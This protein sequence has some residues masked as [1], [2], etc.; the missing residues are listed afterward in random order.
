MS[1]TTGMDYLDDINGDDVILRSGGYG[2]D[3][4]SIGDWTD[5]STTPHQN[6]SET[7]IPSQTGYA[8]IAPMQYGD[9][10]SMYSL[11]QPETYGIQSMPEPEDVIM[12]HDSIPTQDEISGAEKEY[13]M[14]LDYDQPYQQEGF[15]SVDVQ[16][17]WHGGQVATQAGQPHLSTD[18]R[19]VQH[20][21]PEQHSHPAYGSYDPANMMQNRQMNQGPSYPPSDDSG[22]EQAGRQYDI[23]H[24][25]SLDDLV[26]GNWRD[27][28]T[29]AVNDMRPSY[30]PWSSQQALQAI[31]QTNWNVQV[32]RKL[33]T[34]VAPEGSGTS[35]TR[36]MVTDPSETPMSTAMTSNLASSEDGQGHFGGFSEMTIRNP[37]DSRRMHVLDDESRASEL[38]FEPRYV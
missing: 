25:D 4:R 37:L 33:S 11:V 7:G 26:G 23:S 8:E 16:I 12:A 34:V 38:E 35:D 9:L 28:V 19:A 22:P 1:D 31:P 6:Q 5:E 27:Y 20:F 36:F 24:G 14:F 30:N 32:I 18:A 2:Q 3:F 21:V 29:E 13:D 17:G 15:G 10:S